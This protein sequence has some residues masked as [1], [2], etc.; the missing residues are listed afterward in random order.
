MAAPKRPRGRPRTVEGGM[1][2]HTV[3][4]D[5]ASV[6]AARELGKGNLSA[7]VRAALQVRAGLDPKATDEPVA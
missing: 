3:T 7:G 4:L 2:H 5:H 6:T 1:S